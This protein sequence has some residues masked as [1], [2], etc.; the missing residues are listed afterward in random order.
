[1]VRLV[2]SFPIFTPFTFPVQS[3]IASSLIVI[4]P[5]GEK[6]P[7][8]FLI[9]LPER[10]KLKKSFLALK[11]WFPFAFNS[12]VEPE[13]TTIFPE[14]IEEPL[15]E[16]PPVFL[17]LKDPF[18]IIFPFVFLIPWSFTSNAP[19]IVRIFPARLLSRLAP[20]IVT[21]APKG[22]V[23]FDNKFRF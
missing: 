15:P 13:L 3:K 14:T 7:F 18:K 16:N 23:E 1:M 20:E 5:K 11:V 12:I 21:L 8:G 17:V 2:L 6:G 9:P 4:V 19:F 22:I 10:I